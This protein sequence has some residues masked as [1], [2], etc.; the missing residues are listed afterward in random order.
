MR[1]RV[2]KQL[3]RL[4]LGLLIASPVVGQE[5]SETPPRT[6]DTRLRAAL[7]PSRDDEDNE[8]KKG[9]IRKPTRSSA[10]SVLPAPQPLAGRGGGGD[11][12]AEH[13]SFLRM[14]F[15]LSQKYDD[16]VFQNSDSVGT[17]DTFSQF[18]PYVTVDR[19]GRRSF[20]SFQYSG[21]GRFYA[22]RPDLNVFGHNVAARH[23]FQGTRWSAGFGL[24]FNYTP[25]PLSTFHSQAGGQQEV[26]NL[27]GPD[28][29]L[30]TPRVDRFFSAATTEL[31]YRKSLR[32]SFT[33]AAAYRDARSS[34]IEF[35]DYD[36][37]ALRAA[38]SYRHSPRGTLSVFPTVRMVRSELGFGDFKSYAVFLGHSYQVGERVW[39]SFHGGPEYSQL[40]QFP[41]LGLPPEFAGLISLLGV[42]VPE[43]RSL[44]SWA[45]GAN[46]VYN[47][48][49]S[50]FGLS[51]SRGVTG[52]GGS[53]SSV[54]NETVGASVLG[55][56]FRRWSSSLGVSY[57]TNRNLS[58]PINSH[59]SLRASFRLEKQVSESASLFVGY[60][61]WRQ[62]SDFSNLSFTR[63][64]FAVGIRW[65][66]RPVLLG[67]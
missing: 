24:N 63:N 64:A 11:G 44:T 13:R 23:T 6:E 41:T 26:N 16:N 22:R 25:D 33:V 61:F 55:R 38:Y 21:D 17:G 10:S 8:V 45:G 40:E 46:V 37:V 67:R 1:Q 50:A 29:L 52:S 65:G 18:S 2:D 58:A 62:L 27:L 43:T 51:Y 57:S 53:A 19:N 14:G 12:A 66:F 32:T 31:G 39:V 7:W 28:A 30:V 20:T 5:A 47:R 54:R 15:S 56:L 49:R 35:N 3:C 60:N 59:E 42:T 4:V 48:K 36:E 9:R 34:G